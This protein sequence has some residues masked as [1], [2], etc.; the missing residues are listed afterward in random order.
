MN[1]LTYHCEKKKNTMENQERI[2]PQTFSDILP[3]SLRRP[4]IKSKSQGRKNKKK[5]HP[6]GVVNENGFDIFKHLAASDKK[7]IKIDVRVPPLFKGHSRI[8]SV[9]FKIPWCLHCDDPN[10]GKWPSSNS[11][12]KTDFFLKKKTRYEMVFSIFF[13]RMSLEELRNRHTDPSSHPRCVSCFWNSQS[14]P[15][16]PSKKKQDLRFHRSNNLEQPIY[17]SIL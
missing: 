16:L 8:S 13:R 5:T 11:N 15:M 1:P 17:A 12:S 9:F 3:G 4:L 14:F 10:N 2:Q 6:C 7:I